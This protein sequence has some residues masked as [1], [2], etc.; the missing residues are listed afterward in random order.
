MR[1]SFKL[2]VLIAKYRFFSMALIV[3]YGH[4]MYVFDWLISK[5]NDGFSFA[6]LRTYLQKIVI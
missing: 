3:L 2:R 4:W 5:G 6:T 1:H